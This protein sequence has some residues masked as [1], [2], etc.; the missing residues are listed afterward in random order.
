MRCSSAGYW[1]PGGAV[2]MSCTVNKTVTDVQLR[3]DT[4]EKVTLEAFARCSAEI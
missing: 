3:Q 4:P 2:I 1:T